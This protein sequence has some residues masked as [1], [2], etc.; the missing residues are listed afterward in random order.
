[1]QVGK[2]VF[3]ATGRGTHSWEGRKKNLQ[4]VGHSGE[5]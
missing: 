2:V 3:T 4:K 5:V 1:M